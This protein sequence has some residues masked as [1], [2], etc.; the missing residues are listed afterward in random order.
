MPVAQHVAREVAHVDGQH[1]VAPAQQRQRAAGVDEVDRA[2]RAG[3]EL[4]PVL[5]AG[6]A[7]RGGQ[8]DGVLHHAPVDVDRVRGALVARE[9]LRARA[10]RGRAAPPSSERSTTATSSR[11]RG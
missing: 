2:A 3:A 11:C 1:V 10:P 8:R 7:R 5:L 9:R 4:D 6:L